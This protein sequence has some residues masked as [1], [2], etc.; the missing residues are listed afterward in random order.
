MDVIEHIQMNKFGKC[1]YDVSKM[2]DFTAFRSS[3]YGSKI[4][5]V[6]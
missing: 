5:L 6:R 1:Y 4:P 2:A 3:V